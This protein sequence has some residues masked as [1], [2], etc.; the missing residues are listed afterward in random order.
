M[1]FSLSLNTYIQRKKDLPF[2]QL[3][4]ETIL[5]D[6]QAKEYL[7]LNPLGSRIWELLEKPITFQKLLDTLLQEYEVDRETLEKDLLHFLQDLAAREFLEIVK[8]P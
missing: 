1:K 7:K 2:T 8:S 3:G 5:L 6:L 4:E